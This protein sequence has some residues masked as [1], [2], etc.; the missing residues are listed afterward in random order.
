MC[1][2][3]KSVSERGETER[4]KSEV[5]ISIG[6]RFGTKGVSKTGEREKERESEMCCNSLLNH[7]R[8]CFYTH[9]EEERTNPTSF[10]FLFLTFFLV[11]TFYDMIN[12][13]LLIEPTRNRG[14][15][16]RLKTSH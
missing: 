8:L 1:T 16:L 2:S 6:S 12:M 3:K 7:A 5:T 15:A 11:F 10:F 4:S 9:S 13:R 14:R